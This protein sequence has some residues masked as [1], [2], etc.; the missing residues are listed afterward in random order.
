MLSLRQRPSVVPV[1]LGFCHAPGADM[2]ELVV[3]IENKPLNAIAHHSDPGLLQHPINRWAFVLGADES[4]II[5]DPDRIESGARAVGD[6]R[7][8]LG[9]SIRRPRP[10]RTGC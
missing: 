1:I 5:V 3:G 9:L 4:E 8:G 10:D 6:Y 2:L 7:G